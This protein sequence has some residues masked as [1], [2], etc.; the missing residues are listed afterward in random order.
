MQ[1]GYVSITM[2]IQIVLNP[3]KNP[4]FNKTTQKIPNKVFLPEKIP[5][6]K[7]SLPKKAFDHPHHLKFQSTPPLTPLWGNGFLDFS[8]MV[9]F[10]SLG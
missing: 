4:Y 7:I 9:A 1:L 2:S 5:E 3:Q 10:H 8:F 6:S